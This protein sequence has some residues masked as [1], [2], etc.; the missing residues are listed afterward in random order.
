MFWEAEFHEAL[1]SWKS[2]LD[3]GDGCWELL[4]SP[5]A[6]H[7]QQSLEEVTLWAGDL[8]CSWELLQA[9]GSCRECLCGWAGRE[10]K[11]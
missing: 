5:G 8:Q 1:S 11:E 2:L 10:N 3:K 6:V 9:G 4:P 7:A